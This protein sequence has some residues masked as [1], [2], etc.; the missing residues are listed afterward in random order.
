MHATDILTAEHLVIEQVL[1]CLE[2]LARRAQTKGELDRPA[3]EQALDFFRTFADQCHHRKEENHLFPALEG[4]G[5]PRQHGPTGVMMAEHEQ[6][7]QHL[8]A[9]ARALEDGDAR[10][11]AS[12]AAG[13]VS[14]LRDHILKENYRLFPMADHLLTA[15]DQKALLAAFAD[16]EVR[17]MHHGTHEKYLRIADELADRC[18]VPRAEVPAPSKHGCCSCGSL[19]T[20]A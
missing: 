2:V 18:G 14:L 5:L 1:N 3:A 10:G 6:G 16:V 20:T 15:E 13:Y 12:Q 11:F 19:H 7:R 9:M 17:E 4:R 8:Q